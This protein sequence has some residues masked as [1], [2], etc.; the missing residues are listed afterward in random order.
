MGIRSCNVK[1]NASKN[2][3]AIKFLSTI[4][5][6]ACSG[7]SCKALA[8]E[9]IYTSGGI[10]TLE[11]YR[12]IGIIE[13]WFWQNNRFTIYYLQ[14]DRYEQIQQSQLLPSLDFALLTQYVLI[15]DPLEAIIE[16]RKQIKVN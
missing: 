13:V 12:R 11:I 2:D 3:I 6:F 16:W 5:S 15:S 8:I 4:A 7:S 14:G 10:D 9:V 1:P